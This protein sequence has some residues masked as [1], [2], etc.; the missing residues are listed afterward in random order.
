VTDVKTM[1]RGTLSTEQLAQILRVLREADAIEIRMSVPEADGTSA[2]VALDLDPLDAQIRQ[3]VYFDSSELAL[4]RCGIAI[5]ARRIQD[6]AGDVT[7]KLRPFAPDQVPSKVRKS[8]AFSVEVDDVPGGFVCCG[9]MRAVVDNA[10]IKAVLKRQQPVSTL[11][12]KEQRA[13]FAAYAPDDLQ[14]DD[15]A[16]LGPMNVLRLKFTP[17]AHGRRLV[18]ELWN[19]PDGSRLVELSTKCPTTDAFDV[20]AQ[21][22]AFLAGQGIDGLAEQQTTTRKALEYFVHGR[23]GQDG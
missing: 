10:S 1:S 22:R 6:K 12:T 16:I 2:L 18:A 13:L 15:L 8:S 21:T 11:F 23:N 9:S 19:Y 3:V 5:R 14:L 17:P 4:D 20:A 7:V